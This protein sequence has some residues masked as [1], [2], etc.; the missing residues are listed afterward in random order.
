MCTLAEIFIKIPK[1][2]FLVEVLKESTYNELRELLFVCLEFIFIHFSLRFHF[3]LTIAQLVNMSYTLCSPEMTKCI[4]LVMQ[5]KTKMNW[6]AMKEK[7]RREQKCIS[8]RINIK[9]HIKV[10]RQSVCNMTANNRKR[11]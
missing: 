3:D 10:K 8:Y 7:Q 5:N 2:F 1:L 6:E 11:S 4:V 9:R